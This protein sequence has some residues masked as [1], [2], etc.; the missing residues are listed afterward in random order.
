MVSGIDASG[1]TNLTGTYTVEQGSYNLAYASVKRKFIFR[2]GSSITWTERDEYPGEIVDSTVVAIVSAGRIVSLSYRATETVATAAASPTPAGPQMHQV[3]SL[4][5]PAALAGLGLL[6]LGLVFGMP[7]R[8]AS[9]SHLD[10]RLLD[11]HQ[12]RIFPSNAI[13]Q[14]HAG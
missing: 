3:P 2:K 6:L 10:G 14:T 1:K 9:R 5:W 11:L 8:K 4:A 13:R 12:P 7:R